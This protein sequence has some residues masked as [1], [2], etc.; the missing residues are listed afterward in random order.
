MKSNELKIAASLLVTF[1]GLEQSFEITNAK[2]LARKIIDR[3]FFFRRRRIHSR[4]DF[5]VE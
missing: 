4:C 2:T 3:L 1:D 5:D